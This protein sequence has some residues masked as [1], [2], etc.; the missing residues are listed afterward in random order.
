[1]VNQINCCWMLAALPLLAATLLYTAFLLSPSGSYDNGVIAPRLPS[2]EHELG[3]VIDMLEKANGTV[4]GFALLY[5]KFLAWTGAQW[6][7]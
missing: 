1:M 3:A 5:D 2:H 4:V 6:K 7:G